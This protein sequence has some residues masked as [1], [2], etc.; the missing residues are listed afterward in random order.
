MRESKKSTPKLQG[1]AVHSEKGKK[2]KR[3]EDETA[4]RICSALKCE[5]GQFGLDTS[6][7]DRIFFRDGACKCVAEIKSRNMDM[8]KLKQFGTYLISNSK[9]KYG[10]ELSRMTGIPF[11]LF[12][13][14][15]PDDIIVYWNIFDRHGKALLNYTVET[16]TTQATCEG[17][18]AERENAFLPIGSM[19][20]LK[21]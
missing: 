20:Q 4:D 13:R 1:L 12:V 14:L 7:S 17:G 8:A 2:Y 3:N 11:Y 16:T 21:E 19:F 10:E 15:I 18:K 5:A 9:L 6:H